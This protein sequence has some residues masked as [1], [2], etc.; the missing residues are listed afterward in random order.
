MAIFNIPSNPLIQ[1]N[2]KDYVINKTGDFK[3]KKTE[4]LIKNFTTSLLR[5]LIYK[6]QFGDSSAF[7]GQQILTDAKFTVDDYQE[8]VFNKNTQKYE[9]VTITGS[10]LILDVVLFEISRTKNIIETQI[11]GRNG[12]VAEFINNGDYEIRVSGVITAENKGY[13]FEEIEAFNKITSAPVSIKV[14]SE[15]LALFSIY[16][17]R[18]K[19]EVLPQ[20]EG[21][22]NTQLFSFTASENESIEL[23]L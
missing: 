17:I 20:R 12:S 7:I 10:E 1:P 9:S 2:K 18:V 14:E 11:N 22:T 19:S 16:E 3:T 15:F 4:L 8:E 5:P 23:K 6:S 13:P 21:F